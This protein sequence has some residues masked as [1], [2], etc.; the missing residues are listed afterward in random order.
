MVFEGTRKRASSAMARVRTGSRPAIPP[1]THP[2][3]PTS[4][5]ST[6]RAV[7]SIPYSTLPPQSISPDLRHPDRRPGPPRNNVFMLVQ[8]VERHPPRPRERAVW[9]PSTLPAGL[10]QLHL[11]WRLVLVRR[12]GGPVRRHLA[13]PGRTAGPISSWR[14]AARRRAASVACGQ[15]GGRC[16]DGVNSCCV[17]WRCTGGSCAACARGGRGLRGDRR[18][19]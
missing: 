2:Q 18:V 13:C 17:G 10:E 1:S 16:G 14:P 4:L 9:W 6:R 3:A 8:G 15:E 5:L 19:L 11:A 7:A 12:R